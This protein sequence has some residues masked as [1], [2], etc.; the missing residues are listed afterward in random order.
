MIFLILKEIQT[1][2]FLF[3]MSPL[4]LLIYYMMYYNGCPFWEIIIVKW[5]V[6]FME[7]ISFC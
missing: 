4:L 1:F 5:Y 2:F 3:K 6:N 7:D